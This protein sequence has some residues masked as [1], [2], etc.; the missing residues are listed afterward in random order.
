MRDS[1]PV[2]GALCGLGSAALFGISAPLAKLLLPMVDAWILAGLLYLGAGL[3]LVAWR[4]AQWTTGRTRDAGTRLTRA[5]LPMLFA[6][7]AIG[8]GLGPVLLLIGLERL[9]GVAGALLLNLEAVFTA[10]LAVT[11]F[12][13]RLTRLELCAVVVVIVGAVLLSGRGGSFEG[14]MT[15]FA[16]VGAACLAWGIDN[17]L[18]ARLS[19]RNAVD[20]VRFKALTAGAGN[21]ALA[22]AAG[23]ALPG[24]RVAVFSLCVGFVSYGLSIVLDVY[25]LRYIGAARESAYFATAPFVGAV[26]AI[27]LLGERMRTTEIA[28]GLVMAV[29]V[30]LL[31]AGRSNELHESQAH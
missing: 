7:A 6:I 19:G 11:L 27:P 2:A 31:I 22:A 20:L 9:S 13:E 21:L 30:T 3:G 14:Q 24:L 26:A 25:A 29:G 8:G 1:S 23:H 17:N 18:T 12:G 5:D 16:A 28:A 4:A 10:L 15:G